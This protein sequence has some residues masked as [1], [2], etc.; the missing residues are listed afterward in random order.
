LDPTHLGDLSEASITL[1]APLIKAIV[2]QDYSALFGKSQDLLDDIAIGHLRK[3][4]ASSRAVTTSL[5]VLTFSNSLLPS[6]S[7]ASVD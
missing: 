2:E 6:L 7:V 1:E 3:E 4:S 5:T